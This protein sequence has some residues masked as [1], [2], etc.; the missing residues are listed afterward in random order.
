MVYHGNSQVLE[1]IGGSI[2]L[3]KF[4][5]LIISK[6]PKVFKIY[7]KI[8]LKSFSTQSSFFQYV[9]ETYFRLQ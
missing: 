7:V 1:I 9:P 6:S 5:L 4:V 3:V 8:R 2:R